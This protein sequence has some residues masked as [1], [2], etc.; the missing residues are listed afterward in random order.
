M[1]RRADFIAD[2]IEN[3]FLELNTNPDSMPL[4]D[5]EINLD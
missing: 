1:N 3:K 2:S 5:F 4:F